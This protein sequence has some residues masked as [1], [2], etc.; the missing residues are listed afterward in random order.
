MGHGRKDG[1]HPVL[2]VTQL[3]AHRQ[4]VLAVIEQ[5][6]DLPMVLS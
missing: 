5:S 6:D 4:D 1:T 3:G 2:V